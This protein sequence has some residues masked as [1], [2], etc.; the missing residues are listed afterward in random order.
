MNMPHGAL[1]RRFNWTMTIDPLLD[2]SPE[3]WP[4]WGP[5]RATLTPENIR[6][7]MHL[8][9]ELPTFFRLPR[10]NAPAFPI[11]CCLIGFKGLA[12]QPNWAR[13]LHRVIRDL[14]DDL[15]ACKG[16]LRNKPVMVD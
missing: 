15:A 1:A 10:S 4:K 11:R 9:V 16:F 5:S 3:N 13:R 14:P 6:Q 12:T 8:R 7:R 2:T